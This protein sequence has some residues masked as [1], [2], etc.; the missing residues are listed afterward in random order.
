MVAVVV[1]E[2]T[3]GAP[4]VQLTITGLGI[5]DSLV[6]VW[7]TADGAL[8]P[9]RGARR[10]TMVDADAVTDFD[11]PLGR[12]VSYEVEVISGPSG[13][14]RTTS[15]P[16]VIESETAWIMDPL[17][18]STAVPVVGTHGRD[19]TPYFRGEALARLE[20]ESQVS[21]FDIMGND[22]PMA[23]FGQVMAARNIPM[24][25]STRSAEQNA[26]L[27]DLMLSST[28][29]LFR[30]IPAFGV[31]LPGVMFVSISKKAEIPVDVMMGGDLTWWEMTADT[32]AAPV[33]KVLTATFSYGDVAILFS[34]YQQKQDALG[35]GATYLD[36][37]KSP[38]G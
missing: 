18:P 2:V 27:R 29:L 17:D 11:V 12:P 14:S 19:G 8:S 30:P 16:V 21:V 4:A 36:D 25:M 38:F 31:D 37:M 34:T 22:R 24:S 10:A 32:I 9:V 26:K 20:Y 3:G 15:G 28:G 1:D 23:L 35:S 5:G 13:A 6:S 33:L 7:R